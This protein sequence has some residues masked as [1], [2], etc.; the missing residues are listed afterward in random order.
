MLKERS[1]PSSSTEIDSLLATSGSSSVEVIKTEY[2]V[3]DSGS[4]DFASTFS[5]SSGIIWSSISCEGLRSKHV[6]CGNC[7]R[8]TGI[9]DPSISGRKVKGWPTLVLYHGT[10]GEQYPLLPGVGQSQPKRD[11]SASIAEAMLTGEHVK[12]SRGWQDTV[13]AVDCCSPL[14]PKTSRPSFE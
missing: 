14:S 10:Q 9:Y 4:E 7:M 2:L 6:P 8:E 3:S 5:S 1:G 12:R 11:E 13:E